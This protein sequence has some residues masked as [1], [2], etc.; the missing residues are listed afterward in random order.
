M[1]MRELLTRES[2]RTPLVQGRN[3]AKTAQ[4]KAPKKGFG[5]AKSPNRLDVEHRP[6]EIGSRDE[7]IPAEGRIGRLSGKSRFKSSC[8]P[9]NEG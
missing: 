7:E 9:L 6:I 4:I 5:K 8:E 1:E 3:D 2:C